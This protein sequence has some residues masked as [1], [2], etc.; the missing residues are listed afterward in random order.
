MKIIEQMSDKNSMNNVDYK[1]KAQKYLDTIA[2]VMHNLNNTSTGDVEQRDIVIEFFGGQISVWRIAYERPS[3]PKEIGYCRV[4]EI[5]KDGNILRKVVA[6]EA[7]L[8]EN[9]RLQKI[10]HELLCES[11]KNEK[12]T[13]KV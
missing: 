7:G 3:N 4:Y 2:G 6:V 5:D 11:R 9:N 1:R 12:K 8:E 13:F 10:L